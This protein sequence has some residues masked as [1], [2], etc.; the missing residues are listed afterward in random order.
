MVLD[1][2]KEQKVEYST[3]LAPIQ[4]IQFTHIIRGELKI[5]QA[6]IG[7]ETVRITALW[8]NHDVLLDKVFQQDLSR[9]F[10][11]FR[12]DFYHVRMT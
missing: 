11:V 2:L 12:G 3:V 4:L 7:F 5:K 6:N 1:T 8:N 9:C 10:I